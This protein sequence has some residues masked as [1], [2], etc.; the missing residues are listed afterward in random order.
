M[1]TSKRFLPH[2]LAWLGEV[3]AGAGKFGSAIAFLGLVVGLVVG[4]L[5]CSPVPPS[6]RSP[7][8]EVIRVITGDTLE[9]KRLDQPNA[10]AERVRL[11]GIDAPDLRQTPWGPDAQAEL[12]QLVVGQAVRLEFIN[13]PRDRDNRLLAYVWQ[14]NVL[15]NGALVSAGLALVSPQANG[16]PYEQQLRH[17]QGEART[18]GRGIWNPTQPLRESPASF[19]QTVP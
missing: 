8:A 6:Q 19:R 11:V 10:I 9:V 13:P 17:S 18:L 2:R 12:S 15:I 14:G 5:A 3:L 16:S 4:L 1:K 7:Q